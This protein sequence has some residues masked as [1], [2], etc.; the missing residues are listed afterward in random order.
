MLEHCLGA[1]SSP[2]TLELVAESQYAF[3]LYIFGCRLFALPFDNNSIISMETVERE[4]SISSNMVD[5][6][7]LLMVEDT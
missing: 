2:N 1:Q 6:I 5:Y 3:F 4:P 7:L